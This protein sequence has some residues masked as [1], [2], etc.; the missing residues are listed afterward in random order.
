M[1]TCKSNFFKGAVAV[2]AAVPIVAA[3]TFAS[4]GSA[5]AAALK[6]TFHLVGN[7]SATVTTDSLTFN[8]PN[9]FNIITSSD[10]FSAFNS[11]TVNN[12]SSFGP[13][14]AATNPLIDLGDLDGLDTFT[15]TAAILDVGNTNFGFTPISISVEGF[16][17][18]ASG[19][20]SKGT[21]QF[22]LQASGSRNNVLANLSSGVT[23]SYSAGFLATVPEP[24][25]LL[26]LGVVAA[27]MAV[28]RRRNKTIPS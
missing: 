26:G 12:I 3:T 8:D 24:A 18:S 1:I 5:E 28:S 27:G 23:A 13:P 25:T 21:G 4:A 16:F 15:V 19:D 6:G 10:S 2:L 7:A 17:T 22:T 9:T 14:I 20:I 11:G